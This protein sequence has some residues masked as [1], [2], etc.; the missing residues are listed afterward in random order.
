[1]ES[2]A[3]TVLWVVGAVVALRLLYLVAI[4]RNRRACPRCKG[5]GGLPPGAKRT[6]VCPRCNGDSRVMTTFV[7]VVRKFD[8]KAREKSEGMRR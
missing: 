4:T 1:M 8:A 5:T 7:R 6:R 2:F 3:Q